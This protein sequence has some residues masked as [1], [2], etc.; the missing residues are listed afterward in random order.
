MLIAPAE[1]LTA[2]HCLYNPRTRAMLEAVSLHVLFGFERDGYRWH[3]LVARYVTGPGYGGPSRGPLGS[4]WARLTLAES[5]PVQPLPVIAEP[6]APGTAVVLAG[7]NQDRIQ[8][9]L[10]DLDCHVLRAAAAPGGGALIIHD[11][12]GTHGTSGGPLLTRQNGGWAVA[13]I[14]IAAGPTDNIAVPAAATA[15]AAD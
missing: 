5:V 14:N 2:A 12:E 4:D 3:R 8:L 11:C 6:I 7:Y 10:A 15:A 9:L 1:V 13:G